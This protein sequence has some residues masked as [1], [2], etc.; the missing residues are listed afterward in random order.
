[1]RIRASLRLPKE[2]GAWTMLYVPFVVGA[3]VAASA[4]WQMMM[5]A[6]SV[7]FFFI[8]R[9]SLLVWWRA[10][11]RGQK[12]EGAQ[13]L[14]LVY[15]GLAALFGGPLVLID[16]LYGLVIAGLAALALLTFNT[17]QAARLKDR[18]IGGELIAILGLTLTAPM[19][20]YVA[21]GGWD[22]TALWLWALC[23]LYFMSS[24]FYIKL[25]VYSLNPRKEDARRRTWQ[26]CAFY[27][28]FLLGSLIVL[29]LTRSLN[30][31]A[32]I[33]F[34]P[35]LAR[36]FRQLAYPA[37]QT[38]LRR[39]GVLEILYSLVFLVF[40]TLTFRIA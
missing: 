37:S 40:I 1:M 18:T 10:R 4:S 2:H 25:R 13:R 28:A 20:Y 16:H 27:H 30:L 29:A 11:C 35:V 22:R 31:F 33:A 39:V 14:M 15:G 21:R 17:Y 38:N 7:T 24:V 34:A 32:L 26:H 36:S 5:L 23:A 12:Q 19:A 3:L 9:E 6:L 8:A